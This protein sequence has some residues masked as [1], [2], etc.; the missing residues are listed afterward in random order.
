MMRY[1]LLSVLVVCV[2]GIMVP[3]VIAQ[4]DTMIENGI[5]YERYC[6][7]FDMQN[8][9]TGNQ[10]QG[11]VETDRS[12]EKRV[13]IPLYTNVIIIVMAIVAAISI[14]AVIAISRKKKKLES[15]KQKP[16]EKKETSAFC[17]NCGNTL[18]PTAKFCGSCGT[19]IA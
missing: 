19:S 18:K 15:V 2:I 17:D 16:M 12:Y 6:D 1:L 10:C 3:S 4:S 13:M 14:I 9:R 7:L 5:Q 8:Q 11:W